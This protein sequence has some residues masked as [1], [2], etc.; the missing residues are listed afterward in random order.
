MSE[1][2]RNISTDFLRKVFGPSTEHP[3]YICSLLNGD[4]RDSETVNERFVTTRDPHDVELFM[5]KWDRA[6]RA[7]YWAVNTVKP[8][9]RRRRH[10]RHVRNLARQTPADD[11]A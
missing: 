7:V 3:I 9:A 11:P 10:S 2:A 6:K 4:A 8:N 1:A 5:R